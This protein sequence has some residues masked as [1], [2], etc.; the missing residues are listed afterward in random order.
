[1]SPYE[2]TI[3][4]AEFLEQINFSLSIEFKEKWRHRFS[5]H[6]IGIFQSRVLKALQDRKP[7]K[8]STLITL[9]HKKH[10]Y[11]MRDIEEFFSLIDLG[12]YHPFI[13]ND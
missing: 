10:K 13:Y 3:E 2:D 11:S 8:K 4:M 7:L 12:L 9:L 1:M 6:F 5:V